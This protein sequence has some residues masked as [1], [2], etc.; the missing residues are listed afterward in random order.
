MGELTNRDEDIDRVPELAKAFM[1]NS[2]DRR[3]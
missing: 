2:Y 3:H 1:D